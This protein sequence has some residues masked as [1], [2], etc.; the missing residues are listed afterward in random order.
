MTRRVLITGLGPVSG[1]GLGVAPTW[2]ALCAGR[3]AIGR[4]ETFDPSGFASQI[5]A[6]L[7][8]F[9]ITGHVPKTYRKATK[10]M[11]RDIQLAVAAADLAVRN[12]GLGTKATTASAEKRP[13]AVGAGASESGSRRTPPAPAPSYAAS[14]MATHVGAGLIAAD[15]DELTYAF[16]QAT[17]ER[18]DLDLHRWGRDGISQ[19]TPLWLLKYLPNMLSSHVSILHDA[20]GPSNTLTCAEASGLLSI[21]ESGRVIQRGDADLGL[22]GGMESKLNLMGL[23]RQLYTGRLNTQ[24]NDSPETAVRP[25]DESAA[26]TAIGEGGAVLVL[27]ARETFEARGESSDAPAPT[28]GESN[29]KPRERPVYAELIGFGASQSVHRE[30]RNALPDPAGRGV[31]RAIGRALREAE[32]RPEDVDLIVANGLGHPQTDHAEAQALQSTFGDRLEAIRVVSTK[33]Y[34][35]N[36][37]AGASAFDVA[38]AALALSEQTT[39]AVLNCDRPRPA[40]LGA[41]TGASVAREMR[42]ALIYGLGAGGQNA[43]VVL[44]RA[45]P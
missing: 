33:P 21:G 22:A 16:S 14:R 45:E 38:V 4:I 7:G 17:D 2:E 37:M 32:L 30:S 34:I 41:R 13:A 35:G 8:E 9:K 15:L 19:L 39:P 23:L 40:M 11:A 6:E 1:L 25:F 5:G 26:G 28:A 36:C 44:R 27:E 12:A 43:A 10:V 3:G 20:Q 18:G 29:E 31:A 24:D 42:H